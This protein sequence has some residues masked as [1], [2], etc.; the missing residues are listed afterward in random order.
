MP[1]QCS[2]V[3]VEEL[4]FIVPPSFQWS[5]PF[6][7]IQHLGFLEGFGTMFFLLANFNHVAKKSLGFFFEFFM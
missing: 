7:G 2:Q 4:M 3:H 6:I 1:T 5:N